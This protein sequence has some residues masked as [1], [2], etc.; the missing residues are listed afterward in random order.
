MSRADIGT[1]LASAANPWTAAALLLPS[2]MDVA[3]VLVG[4]HK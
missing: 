4:R 2:L 1:H 3:D